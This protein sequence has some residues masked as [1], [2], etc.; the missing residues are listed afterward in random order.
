MPDTLSNIPPSDIYT[1]Q[2]K[3]V[4]HKTPK[5][6]EYN[7]QG[8][9]EAESLVPSHKSAPALKGRNRRIFIAPFQGLEMSGRLSRDS[10]SLHPWLLYSDPLGFYAEHTF[11]EGYSI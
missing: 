9:S 5:G 10:A 4:P 7:S 11:L 6:S 3:Y 1:I 2:E 8:W